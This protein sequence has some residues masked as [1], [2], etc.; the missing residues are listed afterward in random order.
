MERYCDSLATEFYPIKIGNF[1]YLLP[2]CGEHYWKIINSEDQSGDR[3]VI[4]GDS[5]NIKG[6]NEK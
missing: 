5:Y 1:T 6:D 3:V 2:V 4:S